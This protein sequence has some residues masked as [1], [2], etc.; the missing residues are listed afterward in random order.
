ME[1]A[2]KLYARRLVGPGDTKLHSKN[3]AAMTASSTTRGCAERAR[4]GLCGQG[5]LLCSQQNET[6]GSPSARPVS[7][8]STTPVPRCQSQPGEA[9][10]KDSGLLDRMLATEQ[11]EQTFTGNGGHAPELRVF[12]FVEGDVPTWHTVEASAARCLLVWCTPSFTCN[13]HLPIVKAQ[14]TAACQ[15]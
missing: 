5:S 1:E 7:I 2:S 4:Q 14:C 8:G 15:R 10:P 11:P 6:R 13:R 9:S 3:A 12:V